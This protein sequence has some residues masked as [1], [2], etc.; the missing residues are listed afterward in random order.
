MPLAVFDIDGTL[1]HT[2]GVDDD[3]F[4]SAIDRA[5]GIAPDRYDHDWAQYPHA[6]D[7]SLTIEAVRRATGTPATPE[8]V[9]LVHA[10]F[11]ELLGATLARDPGRFA[12]VRGAAALLELLAA[13]PGWRVAIATGAWRASAQLK[14]SAAQIA[15][16]RHPAAFADDALS[17]HDITLHAVARALGRRPARL[18]DRPAPTPADGFSLAQREELLGA[19]R[20]RHGPIVYIGDGLWD[21]RTSADLGVGFVGLRVQG[22]H[23]HLARHGAQ[24][25]L[26]DFADAP[27]AVDALA[28][29]AR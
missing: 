24:R 9:A 20:A 6:T 16:E 29:A 28:A 3:C 25:V 2:T 10:E 11:V 15:L 1:T 4:R 18:A 5:L 26:T 13:T 22:D 23:D 21:L 14:T 27:A 19:A 12:P 7:G 8:Q 17:R